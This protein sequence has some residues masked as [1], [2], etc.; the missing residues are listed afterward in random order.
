MNRTNMNIKSVYSITNALVVESKKYLVPSWLDIENNNGP[1]FFLRSVISKVKNTKLS[2]KKAHNKT[3]LEVNWDPPSWK[4]IE[5][6][7]I[8]YNNIKL[9]KKIKYL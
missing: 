2:F 7:I 6:M 1:E 8:E 3:K 4:E 9:L 5:K